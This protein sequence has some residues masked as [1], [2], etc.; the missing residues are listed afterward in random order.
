MTSKVETVGLFSD[1]SMTQYDVKST[2][3]KASEPPVPMLQLTPYE[4]FVRKYT[5]YFM[6]NNCQRCRSLICNGQSLFPQKE[7]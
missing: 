4:A 2:V 1:R 6:V 3:T 7:A 5:S